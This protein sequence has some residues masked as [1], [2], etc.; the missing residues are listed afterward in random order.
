MNENIDPCENKSSP[1]QNVEP[2]VQSNEI[3]T[4]IISTP[5]KPQKQEM[6]NNISQYE[7]YIPF[8]TKIELPINTKNNACIAD[9]TTR[10]TT[11]DS[12]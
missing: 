4:P 9:I 6:E 7:K 12:K 2:P 10:I 11:L 1:I 3:K 8:I 5:K